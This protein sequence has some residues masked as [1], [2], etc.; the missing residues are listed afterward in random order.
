MSWQNL[1]V[2]TQSEK[3]EEIGDILAELGAVAVTFVDAKDT[4]I[5]EPKVGEVSYWPATKVFGLFAADFD[6]APVITELKTRQGSDLIVKAEPLEEKDWTKEWMDNFVP[7]QFGSSLWICPSWHE[8]PDP[9]ATNI[10]L[11]PGLAFGTG[12]HETTSLCL[13]W[14]ASHDIKGKTVIDFGCGSGILAI[15]AIKLGAAKVIGIDI[16]PQA[17]QASYQN[18]IKN[19]V[20]N[21]LSLYSS[22]D[23][24]DIKADVIIANI[25]VGPL[26]ELSAE[27]TNLCKPDGTLVMS[28]ILPIQVG[29]LVDHYK[30]NFEFAVP[31]SKNDW[32]LVEGKRIS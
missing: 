19:N 12:S 1:I 23:S 24:L 17:L 8:I 14:L 26:K 10:M 4:P 2:S 20:E 21:L 7:I 5:Y 3:A 28:G 27:I 9:S 29:Q 25:L 18:A 11:D 31:K 6:C 22:V 32:S 15:A 30:N 13:D 16:D